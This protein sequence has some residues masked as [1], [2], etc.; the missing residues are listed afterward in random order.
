MDCL[1]CKIAGNEKD[2]AIFEN[3]NCVAVLDVFPISKGHTLII[4]KKHYETIL[5]LPDEEIT[6][7][8]Q[9]VKQTTALLRQALA[10]DGFTIGINHG[11]KAGQAIDHLHIHIIPR[12]DGDGGRSIHSIVQNPPKETLEEIKSK[13]LRYNTS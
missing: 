7:V 2:T 11:K 12:F 13:I 4:P 10:P 1:F 6:L 5:D 8:F 3:S 9:A